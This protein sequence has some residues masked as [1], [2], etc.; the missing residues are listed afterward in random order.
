VITYRRC[1]GVLVAFGV[2][3]AALLL[4][5][6]AMSPAGRRIL[7]VQGVDSVGYFATAHSLLFDLDFDLTNEYGILRPEESKYNAIRP[8]TGRPG[9]PWPIG[10]SLLQIP[11]LSLG[12]LVDYLARNPA[13][14]YSQYA[15]SF[16]YL[17]NIVL[18]TIGLI[19]LFQFLY[20]FTSSQL[21]S[22]SEARR[23]WTCLGVTVLLWSSTTLGYATF[24][25]TSHVGGFMAVAV[26]VR[27]WWHVRDSE[28]LWHWFLLGLCGGLAV[29]SR[30]QNALLLALPVLY[31]ILGWRPSTALRSALDWRWLRTRLLFAGVAIACLIPQFIQ[32]KA[33]Y[34]RYVT[35][36]HGDSFIQLPPSF[37]PN[38]LFSARHG[39]FIWTP[40]T[41]LCVIGLL[42]GCYRAHRAFVPLTTVLFLEIAL[43]GS[44]PKMWHASEAFGMRT[45][46][47][48]L[49]IA[50]LGLA[51]LV[52]NVARR[53]AAL[54]LGVVLVACVLYT[55]LFAVQYRLDLLPRRDWLTS[56][57]LVRDK[58]FLRQAYERQKHVRLA[59]ALLGEGRPDRAIEV[60]ES[61]QRRHGDSRFLLQSLT[62]A[63]RA[64][65]RQHEAE[66]ARQRL[67][68]LLD[69]RLY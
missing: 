26:L 49:S 67:Q 1:H 2:F 5:L 53:R 66:Q 47:C 15:I 32:W 50:A 10:Y 58:I 3:I 18:V 25:S 8:E 46:T 43:L 7:K 69:R 54:A 16:Y 55:F 51:W 27:V 11:A 19:C 35:N 21:P 12:T 13:D 30:W 44:L 39:W 38:V 29:L 24:A 6:N 52:V 62:D 9:S 14:G 48:S 60:L 34:G 31:D 20:A 40:I 37:I 45:L 23:L 28:R 57:E 42:Y 65:G 17:G 61:A 56:D 4:T 22:V 36:P 41:I 59:K 68:A 63:Y 33:I 64:T